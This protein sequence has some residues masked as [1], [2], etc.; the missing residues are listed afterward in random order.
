M[1][2][3]HAPSGYAEA[4]VDTGGRCPLCAGVIEA[5]VKVAYDVELSSRL[6]SKSEPVIAVTVKAVRVT[7]SALIPHKCA[8]PEDADQ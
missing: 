3:T 4:T 1:N 8:F 5:V 7:G 2:T 6:G